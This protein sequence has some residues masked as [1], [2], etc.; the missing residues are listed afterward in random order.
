[1]KRAKMLTKEFFALLFTVLGEHDGFR[2]SHRI[3]NHPF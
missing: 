3:E 1:M 2:F